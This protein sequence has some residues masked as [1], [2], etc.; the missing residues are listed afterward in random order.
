V[1]TFL[2]KNKK[3]EKKDRNGTETKGNKY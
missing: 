3:K 2:R 1:T